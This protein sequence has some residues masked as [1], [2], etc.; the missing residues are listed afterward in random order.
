MPKTKLT[1]KQLKKQE[2]DKA[3]A[4]ANAQEFSMLRK[5]PDRQ[6][7]RKKASSFWRKLASD[8]PARQQ[9]KARFVAQVMVFRLRASKVRP[10]AA[11]VCSHGCAC[12]SC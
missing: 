9:A 8:C 4:A 7:L 11:S 12:H 1:T 10:A 5:H 6:V 3:T 2:K